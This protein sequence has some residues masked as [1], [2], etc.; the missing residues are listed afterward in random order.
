MGGFGARFSGHL[1]GSLF[2]GLFFG[3][4]GGFLNYRRRFFDYGGGFLNYRGRLFNYRGGFLNHRGRLFNRGWRFF[5]YGGSFLNYRGRLFDY[6]RR[7]FNRGRHLFDYGRGFLDHRRRLFDHRGGF[8]NHGRSFLNHGRLLFDH[9][10]S[11]FWRGTA[12]RCRFAYRRLRG[13]VG[14]VR[15]LRLGTNGEEEPRE[16]ERHNH[17]KS[18]TA[19]GE[20]PC[21][22]T[23]DQL[24]HVRFY[25][26]T[27]FRL[28]IVIP[29]LSLCER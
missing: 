5:D 10:R 7:F 18:K 24:D 15:P 3:Y 21:R 19:F 1:A 13:A 20:D 26:I 6:G 23:L 17:P 9:R 22:R 25:T 11:F 4:G 16:H 8:F 27:R 2:D 28:Q 12:F 14:G 29:A